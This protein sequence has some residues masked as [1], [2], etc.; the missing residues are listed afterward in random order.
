MY[1]S[2]L[3]KHLFEKKC[4]HESYKMYEIISLVN[5]LNSVKL[6]NTLF[7]LAFLF[8]ISLRIKDYSEIWI[9]LLIFMINPKWSSHGNCKKKYH[10][11]AWPNVLL[12]GVTKLPSKTKSLRVSSTASLSLWML[13]SSPRRGSTI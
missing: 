3:S 11:K 7:P 8:I 9:M 13:V 4:F 12:S 6:F 10:L 5:V 2:N 1:S